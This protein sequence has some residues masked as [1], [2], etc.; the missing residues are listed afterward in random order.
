MQLAQLNI[1]QTFAQTGL[2]T[3]QPTMNVKQHHADLRIQQEHANLVEISTTGQRLYIDQ[4]EAFADAHLKSP[5][6]HSLEFYNSTKQK[7]MQYIAKTAQEGEQLK[8][9]DRGVDAIRSIAKQNYG[10]SH[11]RVNIAYMPS[12]MSKVVIDYEPS[13]VHYH[14]RKSEPKIQ[15]I[16]REPDITIPRWETNVYIQQ[17]NAIAF[18]A[19][20][21]AI[22][23]NL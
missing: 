20:G 15:I 7:T 14:V 8:R 21:T 11:P 4:T 6:R 1:Y 17:K 12:S 2:Q 3:I 10:P 18:E 5:L 13:E 23:R 16:R 19:T 22:D 9:I